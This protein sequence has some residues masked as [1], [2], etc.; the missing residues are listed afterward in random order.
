MLPN[1]CADFQSIPDCYPRLSHEERLRLLAAKRAALRLEANALVELVVFVET[2][3]EERR[4][5]N[6]GCSRG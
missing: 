3:R 6:G 2:L 1:A 5:R 4:G